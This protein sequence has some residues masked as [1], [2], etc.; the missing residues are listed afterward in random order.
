MSFVIHKTGED[1]FVHLAGH[2][3]G[4]VEHYFVTF[5]DAWTIAMLSRGVFV[6]KHLITFRLRIIIFTILLVR[7]CNL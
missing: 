3:H 1:D 2:V 6:P 4:N 7:C 5:G